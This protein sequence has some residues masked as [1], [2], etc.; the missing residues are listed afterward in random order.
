MPNVI[1]TAHRERKLPTEEGQR[2]QEPGLTF[3]LNAGAAPE[4]STLSRPL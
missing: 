1:S 4:N 2:S 3:D